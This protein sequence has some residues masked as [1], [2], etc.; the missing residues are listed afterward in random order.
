MRRLFSKQQDPGEEILNVTDAY[1]QFNQCLFEKI[2][3][4]N[5]PEG[6]FNNCT[7]IM[8]VD[9]ILN[10]LEVS[11]E[12]ANQRIS[13]KNQKYSLSKNEDY[14]ESSFVLHDQTSHRLFLNS[15]EKYYKEFKQKNP[16]MVKLWSRYDHFMVTVW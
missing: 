1:M 16:G 9:S 8:L 15:F 6:P 7:R 11:Y 2:D 3:D 13:I 14:F 4:P 12:Y 5:H 10:N